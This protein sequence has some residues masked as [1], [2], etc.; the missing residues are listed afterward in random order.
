MYIC[1]RAEPSQAESS[2]AEPSR[3]TDVNANRAN[4]GPKEANHP[5]VGGATRFQFIWRKQTSATC[6][7]LGAGLRGETFP[8]NPANG[9]ATEDYQM[10][11]A[12]GIL[13]TF[14]DFIA[15]SGGGRL[16]RPVPR[17]MAHKRRASAFLNTEIAI[18][19][20]DYIEALERA[21]GQLVLETKDSFGYR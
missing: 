12:T 19:F 8:P 18:K 2:R 6:I 7:A 21:F 15:S 13:A 20:H 10:A 4:R 11:P 14:I 5:S 9:N 3:F 17:V 16:C 1:R